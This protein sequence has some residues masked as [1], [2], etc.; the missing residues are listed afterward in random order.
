MDSIFV[1]HAKKYDHQ[2]TIIITVSMT[3]QQC[4]V[5]CAVFCSWSQASPSV[6]LCALNNISRRK[7]WVQGELRWRKKTKKKPRSILVLLDSTAFLCCRLSSGY[8]SW[9]KSICVTAPTDHYIVATRRS[10]MDLSNKNTSCCEPQ[11]VASTQPG[12]HSVVS[13]FHFQRHVAFTLFLKVFPRLSRC[14][15]SGGGLQKASAANLRNICFTHCPW[16]WKT[17]RRHLRAWDL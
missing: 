7:K 2:T 11:Q 3:N 10:S 12:R 1:A 8:A 15:G 14:W 4:A 13:L 5:C 9:V 16:H 6:T 17:S